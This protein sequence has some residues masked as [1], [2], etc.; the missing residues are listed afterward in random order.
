MVHPTTSSFLPSGQRKWVAGPTP[1]TEVQC[2]T[3]ISATSFLI[4][5][6]TSVRQYDTTEGWV[7]DWVWPDLL[8]ERT[9]PGCAVNLTDVRPKREIDSDDS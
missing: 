2:A 1:P 8:L 4:F 3:G 6:G 9:R 7:E 5:G